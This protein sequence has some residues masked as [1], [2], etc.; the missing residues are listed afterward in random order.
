MGSLYDV[1]VTYPNGGIMLIPI[2][3]K[4]TGHNLIKSSQLKVMN[5]KVF[6]IQR[7][8]KVMKN[9]PEKIFLVFM[10]MLLVYY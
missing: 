10:I 3:M 1:F 5:S 6:M 8:P 4:I 2:K 7:V 9:I